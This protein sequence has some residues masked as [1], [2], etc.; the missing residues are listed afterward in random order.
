MALQRGSAAR[1]VDLVLPINPAGRDDAARMRICLSSLRRHLDVDAVGQLLLV[2]PND[3][4]IDGVDVVTWDGRTVPFE[5]RIVHD[6]ELLG[7][8]S[9]LSVFWN[10]HVQQF[11]KLSAARHLR[12]DFYITLDADVILT[13]W[14]TFDDL[15][16]DG[17]AAMVTCPRDVHV[18]W[19]MASA[20]LLDTNPNISE[21]GMNVTPAILSRNH[22]LDLLD[23]L[24]RKCD[25][26]WHR[27]IFDL[28]QRPD[29]VE[30]RQE[31]SDPGAW[32]CSHFP[33]EYTLY[34][35]FAELRG[36]VEKYHFV[37]DQLWHRCQFFNPH[38][39]DDIEV[40]LEQARLDQGHFLVFQ[41]N[42]GWSA[43]RVWELVRGPF[44]LRRDR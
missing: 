34:Y 21:L 44:D 17:R 27:A 32:F 4:P 9:H 38:D 43:E 13:R 24:E 37:S 1:K 2:V 5:T 41:S 8:A 30:T 6:R 18:K 26:P 28:I 23:H 20:Q 39:L 35:L 3:T 14:T 19:W 29:F 12:S 33:T 25:G 7:D 15:V 42:L 11:I 40:K 22:V 36:A 16:V 10:W 31:L